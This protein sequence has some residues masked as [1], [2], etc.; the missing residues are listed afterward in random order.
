MFWNKKKKKEEEEIPV[1]MIF[2]DQATPVFPGLKQNDN[3]TFSFSL[4]DMQPIPEPK[5]VTERLYVISRG[6]I[7][8]KEAQ[9]ITVH[10][11]IEHPD[12]ADYLITE[13]HVDLV[14]CSAYPDALFGEYELKTL[15]MGYINQSEGETYMKPSSPVIPIEGSKDGD[16][17][18]IL[19]LV[20]P[21]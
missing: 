7:D 8:L 12:L 17:Y 4:D 11:S 10:A 14:W 13:D 15:L 3:G 16:D 21:E 5:F 19:I 9:D 18:F 6:N 2:T 20:R 1:E